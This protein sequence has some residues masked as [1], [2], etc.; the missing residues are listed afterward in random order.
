MITL[1]FSGFSL[2]FHLGHHT[3]KF[4]RSCYKR[5][6]QNVLLSWKPIV[7]YSQR[8]GMVGF[9]DGGTRTRNPWI[10]NPVLWPLSYTAQKLLLGRSWVYPVGILHHYIFIIS[11]LWLTSHPR[12]TVV[13]LDTGTPGTSREVYSED[14]RW[15]DSDSQPLDYKPSALAIELYNSKAIAGKEFSWEMINM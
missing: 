1:V 10:T 3:A 5:L 13:L 2:I 14:A 15:W 6:L 12:S 11:Q 4:G 7:Q 9:A 8:T